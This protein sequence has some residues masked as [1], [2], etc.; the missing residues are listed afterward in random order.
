[1]VGSL[2]GCSTRWWPRVA[3]FAEGTVTTVTGSLNIVFRAPTPIGVQLR[4]EASIDGED[5]RKPFDSARLFA[6]D[7]LCAE[8][9]AILIRIPRPV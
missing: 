4:L 6:G 8:A 5:G 3:P 2:P 9:Q 1:M 7:T